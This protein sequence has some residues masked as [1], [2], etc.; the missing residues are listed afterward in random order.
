[1]P[2]RKIVFAKGCYYHI[3]NRGV[4]R[5]NIFASSQH[6]YHCLKLVKT[7]F[8][9]FNI[10]MI[11]YCL[12]PNHYHFLVR[13]DGY[14]SLSKCLGFTFD[15]YAQSFNKSTGRVGT[16]FQDRFKAI[17]VE[18]ESYLLHL[19]RYIHLNPME[20]DLVKQPEDWLFSNY[21][22]WIKKRNGN[23]VDHSFITSYF[24]LIEDYIEFVLE[25]EPPGYLRKKLNRYYLE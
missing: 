16:L 3:F 24:P 7:N 4:N 11:A 22:E 2:S 15:A 5:E 12:M 25:Y 13:V 14:D 6:Y 9:K 17:Q 20:A 1:M 21:L 8:H 23:L 10:S 18:D 19:C